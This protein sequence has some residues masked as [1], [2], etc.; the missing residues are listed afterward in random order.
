MWVT[1]IDPLVVCAS[2][3]LQCYTVRRGQDTVLFKSINFS[4]VIDNAL[5]LAIKRLVLR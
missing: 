3:I 4:Y 2:V 1:C 5:N